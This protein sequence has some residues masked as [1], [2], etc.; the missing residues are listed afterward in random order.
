LAFALERTSL[1]R[2]GRSLLADLDLA[3]AAGERLAVIGPSG[4][5]KTSLL[6]LLSASVAP[7]R[8]V[9]RVLGRDTR[10]LSGKELRALRRELGILHQGDGLVRELR[11]VH[12]VLMGRLGDWST[13]R[14]LF[15]LVFPREIERARTALAKVELEHRLWDLP[16]ALSGGE[17][18]RVALARLLVQ[19]PRAILADEPAS[20]LDPRR[21]REAV[22]RLARAAQEGGRTLVVA[23]HA[24]ELIEGHFE[25][26]L[27]LREGKALWLGPVDQLDHELLSEL[28]G[29]DSARL[30]AWR[31]PS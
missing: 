13:A 27:A 9:V 21:S 24:L 26:V 23:L 6:R 2:G 18:Q 25:R 14:A 31:G 3:I 11:V 16:G 7:T 17:Q 8:G 15:S 19:D 5:G 20:S 28:Y 10:A 4:A 30:F 29:T 1:E 12:N 22:G